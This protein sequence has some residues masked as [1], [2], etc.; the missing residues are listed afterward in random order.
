MGSTENG[1]HEKVV[2]ICELEVGPNKM[3]E[4]REELKRLRVRG[5]PRL[6]LSD[7]VKDKIESGASYSLGRNW[8]N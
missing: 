3:S 8:R 1:M 4:L 7:L 6:L 5:Y 2:F